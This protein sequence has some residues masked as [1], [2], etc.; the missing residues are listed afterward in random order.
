[1]GVDY[2]RVLQRRDILAELTL[3]YLFCMM[4]SALAPAAILLRQSD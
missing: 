3:Y 2:I 1:M 4:A